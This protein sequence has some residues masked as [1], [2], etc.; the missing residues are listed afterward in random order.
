[1]G[2]IARGMAKGKGKLAFRLAGMEV[3]RGEVW[4]RGDRVLEGCFAK[5]LAV[6]EGKAG[7]GCIFVHAVAVSAGA[8]PV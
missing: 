4:G 6:S 7:L 3:E 1:M 2:L 5:V 8:C